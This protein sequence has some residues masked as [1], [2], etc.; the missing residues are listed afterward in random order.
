[1]KRLSF[2]LALWLTALS[3]P[4][5]QLDEPDW[6]VL[7]DSAEQLAR[8]QL[9]PEVLRVFESVDRERIETLFKKLHEEF[10]GN[11][12]LDLAALKESVVTI[13]PLL[14]RFEETAPYAAWL[15]TRV[16]YFEVAEEFQRQAPRL[17]PD[18]AAPPPKNP[19]P[20]AQEEIWI[21]KVAKRPW[22]AAAREWV[23][24]LKPVF[25][26]AKA[27]PELVWIAE[28]ESSFDPRARSPEGAVGLFQLMPATAKRY[29]L[30]TAWPDERCKPEAAASAAARYLCDLYQM[31]KDWRLAVA[32]Y[33][34][35]EGRVGKLLATQKVKTYDA[36]ATRLPAET[37]L[38]VPKVQATLARREQVKLVNLPAPRKQE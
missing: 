36:I 10:S 24:K 8:E 30:K 17:P 12:V 21:A 13:L 16:D 15:R 6:E 18:R 14:D 11:Y 38:Y 4:A 2:C 1:M 22:P 19:S 3:V 26:A 33:N 20:K 25:A 5:Q 31:F 7:L 27:P 29:G 34:C 28:V 9:D 37:Q 23:P 35:G 32:A